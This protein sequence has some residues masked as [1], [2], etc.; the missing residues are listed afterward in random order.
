[1]V[2]ARIRPKRLPLDAHEKVHPCNAGPYKILKKISSNACVLNITA[3]YG[4]S[5]TF[6]VEDLILYQRNDAYE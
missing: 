1:M 6:N 3:N 5:S 4:I 2:M